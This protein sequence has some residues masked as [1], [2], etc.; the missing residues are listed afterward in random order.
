MTDF[1]IIEL[2]LI[3]LK[4]LRICF[5]FYYCLLYL[6][7]EIIAGLIYVAVEALSNGGYSSA[8]FNLFSVQKRGL[9]YGIYRS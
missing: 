1:V 6:E 3:L 2:K 4:V 8:L 9:I 7:C 5:P